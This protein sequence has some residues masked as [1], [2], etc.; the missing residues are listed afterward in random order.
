VALLERTTRRDT[1]SELEAAAHLRY[2]DG[3]QL[4]TSERERLTGA[5]Y[6]LGY[7]A[8]ILVKTAYYRFR[9]LG[10]TDDVAGELKG[11][12]ARARVLGF[13]WQGNRHNLE[14]LAALLVFERDAAGAPMDLVEATEFQSRVAAIGAHWS[15]MLRYKDIEA[16][17]AELTEVF[18]DVEWL[19]T[20]HRQL[21]S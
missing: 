11:M 20:N 5:L 18:E 12:S 3:L 14:S 2:F 10:P 13:D 4:A 8:E 1:W 6:M 19:V 9:R 21:W 17:Q 16:V 7:V 15:E